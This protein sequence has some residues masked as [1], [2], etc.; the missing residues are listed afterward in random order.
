LITIRSSAAF[1]AAIPDTRGAG[2]GAGIMA[3]VAAAGA[4][5]GAGAGKGSG[6]ITVVATVIDRTTMVG[7]SI[8]L[9]ITAEE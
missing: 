5:S 3:V 1:A 7:R 4:G 6:I 9:W 8:Y 2:K